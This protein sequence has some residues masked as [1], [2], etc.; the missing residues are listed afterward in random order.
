M[1]LF[2]KRNSIADTRESLQLECMDEALRIGIY[3]SI[4]SYF[5]GFLNEYDKGGIL[6]E[7]WAVL[8]KRPLDEFP[9]SCW[10]YFPV[11]KQWILSCEW[12]EVYD[13]LEFIALEIGEYHKRMI[14]PWDAL[15]DGASAGDAE[16]A[17]FC[18]E[19]NEVL[20]REGS[21][22]IMVNCLVAPITNEIELGSIKYTLNLHD[23]FSAS[24]FHIT[25][26]MGLL[27]NRADPDY[28]NSVKESI[29]AVEAAC[30]AV[31]GDDHAVVSEAV[32][33]LRSEG[34][35]HPALADGWLKLYAFTCD[36]DGIRHA[37]N[38]GE[39]HVDFAIAK[40]MLVS[41][42]AFVNYLVQMDE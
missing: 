9:C 34:Q 16:S 27:S 7:A 23:R 1:E 14:A 4:Y 8:M 11:L 39:L 13:M 10:D 15:D 40:Y 41:C 38:G 17:A 25:K 28:A 35:V 26:A 22:Y 6:K 12:F 31:T 2:S 33:R 37:S 24:R 42:S 30:R 20:I 32:K 19:I 3:N 29:S 21:G 5:W 36:E 18:S